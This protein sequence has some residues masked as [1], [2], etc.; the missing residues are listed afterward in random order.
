MIHLSLF[1]TLLIRTKF[2]RLSNMS[3]EQHTL[4]NATQFLHNTSSTSIMNS[5]SLLIAFS[6]FLLAVINCQADDSINSLETSRTDPKI[7]PLCLTYHVTQG[8][9]FQCLH[10]M[11]L[12]TRKTTR[13]QWFIW[14]I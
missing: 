13:A 3:G 8:T 14:G 6:P 7:F 1:W 10:Y 9:D 4:T 11:C 2:S 5:P 12:P